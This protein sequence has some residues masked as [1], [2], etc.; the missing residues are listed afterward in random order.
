MLCGLR[1]LDVA[2]CTGVSVSSLA[3]AERGG[4]PLRYTEEALVVSFLSARWQALQEVENRLERLGDLRSREFRE[5]SVGLNPRSPQLADGRRREGE[6]VVLTVE[7]GIFEEPG[8]C[9]EKNRN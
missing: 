9:R 8:G 4:K 2:F 5:N 1:Q 3:T 6:L 7:T